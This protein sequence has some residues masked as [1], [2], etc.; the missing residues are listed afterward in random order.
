VKNEASY[1]YGYG[2]EYVHGYGYGY[3]YYLSEKNQIFLK[4]VLGTKV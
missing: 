3:G 1:G 2:Y 4:K